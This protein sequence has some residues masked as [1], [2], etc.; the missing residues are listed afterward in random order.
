MILEFPAFVLIGVYFPAN[1]TGDRDDFRHSFMV[2]LDARVRNLVAQGKRVVLT[3]DLN[4]IREEIDVANIEEQM[5]KS[6]ITTEEYL[7]RPIRRMFNHLL[8]DGKVTG[9]RDEGREKGVL[10]DIC[11]L[12]H[13]GRRGMF[14]CWE[15]KINARPGNFGSRIDYV[16]CSDGWKDWF[17]DSNIQEGLMGSD[18]CP[19]YAVI[20]DKVK[21]CDTEVHIS[22]IMN[23]QGM[24]KDGVR[25][26]EWCQKDILPVSAKL[27]PEFDR[28]RS[29]RDMFTK[30]PSLPLGE[31]SSIKSSTGNGTKEE[32]L[33][34]VS[35]AATSP[36]LTM[37]IENP[38]SAT[39]ES[40]KST[41][42][43]AV[44]PTSSFSS[45]MSQSTSI[46][47]APPTR[48]SKRSKSRSTKAVLSNSKKGSEKGQ[49]SLMGFFKPT[50]PVEDTKPLDQTP[51][52]DNNRTPTSP[53]ENS[54]YFSNTESPDVEF[55]EFLQGNSNNSK[56]KRTDSLDD[57]N[58]PT[59][60]GSPSKSN[61]KAEKDFVDPIVAKESWSKLL[62][63]RVVPKCEHNEFC[64]SMLTKKPGV[65]CGRSFF[66]CP[67]PMGPSGAK[68]KGTEW[69]CS[70][71]IWSS[72]W[73][74][75]DA[76]ES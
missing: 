72:D 71:F 75:S 53:Y 13:P 48:P 12:F 39:Q 68:E 69:R 64:V 65:N 19:V 23:P 26:R 52:D 2:A 43:R 32:D 15:Q 59:S 37:S 24:F 10:W 50:T 11:R 66:V 34:S 7:S 36:P 40:Q 27:I 61:I 30:K 9:A 76:E 42:S 60:H 31:S 4:V 51:D 58:L 38:L 21:V 18:H 6:G 33:K 29:I 74:K 35:Q 44:T 22:D 20:K 1:S 5:R 55:A 63:K 28:R 62:S 46:M 67:R 57:N 49:S 73:S 25:L 16:L 14:T 54:P 8:V 70:T 45:S 3:G 41:M 17:C 56:R 47:A